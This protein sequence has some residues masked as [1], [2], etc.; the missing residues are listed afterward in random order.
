MAFLRWGFNQRSLQSPAIVDSVDPLLP[1][2]ASLDTCLITEL[3]REEMSRKNAESVAR[4]LAERCKEKA[5][6]LVKLRSRLAA[7]SNT[8][9]NI[10]RFDMLTPE[11]SHLHRFTPPA[12][13]SA[14]AST[15]RERDLNAFNID[16]RDQ[17]K[18]IYDWKGENEWAIPL[19]RERFT[20]LQQDYIRTMFT[21]N[22]EYQEAVKKAT[23]DPSA[24]PVPPI[25][26]PSQ[27]VQDQLFLRRLWS[28]L[29]RYD[30]ISGSGYQAALP[31]DSFGVLRDYWGVTHECYASPLNHCLDSF[32]SA[33]IETDRFFGSKGKAQQMFVFLFLFSFLF[34]PLSLSELIDV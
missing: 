10:K 32:G 28:M 24:P 29:A 8:E 15:Y 30:T 34:L 21:N 9:S 3:I 19:N 2:D 27:L 26:T 13:S 12:S 16:E 18:I 1:M 25:P 17:Y 22:K 33:F 20:K 14:A 6:S 4:Q 31:E 11:Q 5:T 23:E 7:N